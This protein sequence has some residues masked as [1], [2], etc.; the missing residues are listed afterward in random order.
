M[1]TMFV[2]LALALLVMGGSALKCNNCVPLTAGGKC[3]NTIETC[4]YN[5]DACVTA[6]FT[7]Y[8]FNYFKR[9]IKL[10]D[11][12]LLQGSPGINAVCCQRDLCN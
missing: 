3:R 1:R 7:T 2:V 4:G 6:M 5:K 12:L 8:P 11:C 9:C 10:S